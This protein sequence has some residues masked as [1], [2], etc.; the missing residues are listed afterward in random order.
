VTVISFDEVV[1]ILLGDVAGGGQ[2]LVEYSWI[3]GSAVGGYFGRAWAVGERVG[4]E[5]SGGCVIPFL[6]D[7]DIDDLATLVDRPGTDR[8]TARRL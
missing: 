8:P 6:G 1:C 4:E 3:C 5:P 2:Q 7:E